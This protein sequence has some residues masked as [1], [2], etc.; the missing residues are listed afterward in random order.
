METWG[1]KLFL[2]VNKNGGVKFALENQKGC[3]D[4]SK[5]I[6]W[7]ILKITLQ[8]TKVHLHLLTS[9]LTAVTKTPAGLIQ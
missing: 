6:V 7:T 4:N 9:T 2:V 5:L 1:A 8:C 3:D